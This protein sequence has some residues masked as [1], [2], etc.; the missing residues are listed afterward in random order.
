VLVPDGTAG[1]SGTVYGYQLTGSMIVSDGNARH[2]DT[3]HR[4]Q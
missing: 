3:V 4:K 2:T 1:H